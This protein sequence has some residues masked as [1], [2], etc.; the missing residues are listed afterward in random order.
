MKKNAADNDAVRTEQ[1]TIAERS[2][3]LFDRNGAQTAHS[4]DKAAGSRTHWGQL[5]VNGK[6][7]GPITY[8]KQKPSYQSATA[9]LTAATP[10]TRD[11]DIG[12]WV[13]EFVAEDDSNRPRQPSTN[14]IVKV[15]FSEPTAGDR[16]GPETRQYWD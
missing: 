7:T 4:G 14:G 3:R 15:P 5:V 11:R 16:E 8:C 2:E 1:V 12:D 13:L 10:T 6:A 9:D